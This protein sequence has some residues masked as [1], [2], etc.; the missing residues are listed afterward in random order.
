MKVL[1]SWLLFGT[2]AFLTA[3][4]ASAQTPP[5]LGLRLFAG[6]SITGTVGSVYVVQSTPDL[7]QTNSWTS[8]A[9]L[10]LPATDFLFVDTSAPAQSN[11]FYRAFLQAPPTNMV[12]IPPNTFRLGSP[13]NEAGRSTDE[14]PQT[15]VTISHGFW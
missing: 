8:L 11:R 5:I 1:R 10:Q 3:N 9:F 12:F 13:T 4:L 15:T 7:A 14:S 6:V 2:A